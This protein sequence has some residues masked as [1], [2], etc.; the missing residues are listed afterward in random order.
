MDREEIL[1]EIARCN[2]RLIELQNEKHRIEAEIDYVYYELN[3]Y[4]EVLEK[5]EVE[6]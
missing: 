1:I 2:E 3:Q 4:N 6:K 5:M